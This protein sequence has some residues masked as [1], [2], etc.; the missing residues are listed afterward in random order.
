M[1]S[2]KF[3]LAIEGHL[4]QTL[5]VLI[6]SNLWLRFSIQIY[7]VFKYSLKHYPSMLSEIMTSNNQK[8]WDTL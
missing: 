6:T 3:N 1:A 5:T 4:L 7:F 2:N 8:K